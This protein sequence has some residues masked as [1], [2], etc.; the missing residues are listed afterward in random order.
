MPIEE[1]VDD[2]DEAVAKLRQCDSTELRRARKHHRR[3]LES[4][5]NGGYSC[6]SDATRTHLAVRLRNN[7][8]ALNRALDAT[9]APAESA[10]EPASDDAETEEASSISSRFRALLRRLWP[11]H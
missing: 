4:L 7:L 11:T 1:P 9:V 3:A 8:E 5:R 2:T 6:L 10:G